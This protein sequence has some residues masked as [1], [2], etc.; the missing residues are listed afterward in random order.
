MS[1][2]KTFQLFCALTLALVVAS[3]VSAQDANPE[4][5]YKQNDFTVEETRRPR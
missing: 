3:V 1:I 4:T 5:L 2:L